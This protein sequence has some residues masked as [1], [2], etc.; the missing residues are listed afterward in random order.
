M[1]T[2]QTTRAIET[3]AIGYFINNVALDLVEGFV[4][5]TDGYGNS[6]NRVPPAGGEVVTVA[7][8]E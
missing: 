4:Y 7:K 3:L 8:R 2:A 1:S 6:I 5:I